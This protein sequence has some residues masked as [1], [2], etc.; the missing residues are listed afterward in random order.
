M[1]LLLIQHIR[2]HFFQAG[3]ADGES[4][5]SL[6]PVEA[7]ELQFLVNPRGGFAFYLAH[8]IGETM[9]GAESGEEVDVIRRAAD[10]V[11]EAAHATDNAAEVFVDAVARGGR[12]PGFTVFGAENQVVV[13]GKVRGGHGRD[14][15]RA[16]A[17]A[18]C[19]GV[20]A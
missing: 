1:V 4:S 18:Q 14:F 11:W 2:A 6:L 8:D 16:P 19:F 3:C 5:I 12:E 10:G 15:S 9:G 20:R 13:Q 17:G 7:G